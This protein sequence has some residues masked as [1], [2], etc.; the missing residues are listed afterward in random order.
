MPFLLACF[1]LPTAR[2]NMT[3]LPLALQQYDRLAL[4][5]LAACCTVIW[6][7]LLQARHLHR[8]P[9]LLMHWA[10]HCSLYLNLHTT[11][12]VSCHLSFV[13]SLLLILM[14][15]LLCLLDN[16][17]A[18]Q[19]ARECLLVTLS[20]VMF[21]GLLEN[22]DPCLHQLH[23][24]LLPCLHSPTILA[25]VC[26]PRFRIRAAICSSSSDSSFPSA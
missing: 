4:P 10:Q 7:I 16:L 12:F 19:L 22:M 24:S 17:P 14:Y 25:A 8:S 23:S 21:K 2:S 6:R 26:L 9:E 13:L 15:L 5:Y 3:G 18:C 1:H 20:P 11:T